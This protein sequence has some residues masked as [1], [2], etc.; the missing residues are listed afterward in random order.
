[1]IRI[2]STV[3]TV[4]LAGMLFVQPAIAAKTVNIDVNPG[5]STPGGIAPDV[6]GVNAVY[7]YT[8]YDGQAVNDTIPVQVC[9][10]G[11]QSD[12]NSIQV[13]F[14][15]ASGNLNGVTVP[16]NQ[17][18]LSSTTTPPSDCRNLSIQIA[19][20]TL[21]LPNPNVADNFVANINLGEANPNPSTGSNKPNITWADIKNF[22]I[23][24][25]VL[26]A[27]SNV[28][29]FLTDSSGLFLTNCSSTLITESGSDDGRFAIVANKKGVEVATNPGQFYFNFVWQNTTGASKTVSV[30]FARTGV[31]P[32][33]A[34]AIH[35]AVFNGYLST[36]NPTV[37]DEANSSGIP[38]GTDDQ[39]SN[40]AVPAGSSLLVTYHLTWEA[41]GTPLAPGCALNC[42]GANQIMS[43]TGNVSGAGINPESCTSGALG[44]KK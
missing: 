39:V 38:D 32:Q 12:W 31:I 11:S 27:V 2:I 30:D 6:A 21:T 41:L 19:S 24:I 18:F 36:V 26:P 43:V 7:S 25:T 22:K 34:Q 3:F 4:L 5:T 42:E 23:Q 40:V 15:T 20:G 8:V 35:S 17:T 28:S 10:T 14:G 9:M 13:S 16:P 1:M 29:C 44:Y 37:F 33:G